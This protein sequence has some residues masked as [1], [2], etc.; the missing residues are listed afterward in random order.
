[1]RVRTKKILAVLLG[2][3]IIGFG[4]GTLIRVAYELNVLKAYEWPADNAPII[5]NCYGSDFSELQ[6]IRAIDYWTLRGHSISFYE[7]NPPQEVCEQKNLYGFIILRKAQRYELSDATLAS[8]T[9]GT[10]GLNILY[11]E[12]VYQPGSQN[13]D[14]INEHELGHALGYGHIEELGHI[15]HPE[16]GKMGRKFWMP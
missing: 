6:M 3:F 1:M 7:H 5:L 4:S 2:L 9:K 12:I 13:L 14:L 16:Y 15:M 10:S 8:T 11:A